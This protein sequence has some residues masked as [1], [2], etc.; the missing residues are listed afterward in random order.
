MAYSIGNNLPTKRQFKQNYEAT[1]HDVFPRMV[2]PALNMLLEAITTGIYKVYNSGVVPFQTALHHQAMRETIFTAAGSLLN[3]EEY[4]RSIK[5]P[6]PGA[7]HTVTG[8]NANSLCNELTRCFTM[9]EG[10]RES[11][12]QIQ[13]W[14][15]S[16]GVD[17]FADKYYS[18]M[19][20]KDK[21]LKWFASFFGVTQ[22]LYDSHARTKLIR[23]SV[24]LVFTTTSQT[25]TSASSSLNS[26]VPLPIAF[27]GENPTQ[28]PDLAG[29]DVG[30]ANL[31]VLSKYILPDL[32]SD[33]IYGDKGYSVYGCMGDLETALHQT[34][35]A[36]DYVGRNT[37]GMFPIME[38]V[39]YAR[40]SVKE[41]YHDHL[42]PRFDLVNVGTSRFVD[43]VS[44][45]IL[46]AAAIYGHVPERNPAHK[47]AEYCGLLFVP[48]TWKLNVVDHPIDD[49]GD[50][51]GLGNIIDFGS[52]SPGVSVK[53]MTS[54]IASMF[55]MKNDGPMKILPKNYN[56]KQVFVPDAIKRNVRI[57][58]AVRV[59]MSQTHTNQTCGA[60][61]LQEVGHQLRDSSTPT[62]VH[63]QA[64]MKIGTDIQ[65]NAKPLLVLFKTDHPRAAQPIVVC[66]T[67]MVNLST[68]GC[69][70]VVDCCPG[71]Q[72]TAT[73]TFD[74][75][76][77]GTFANGDTVLYRSGLHGATV[78]ATVSNANGSTLTLTSTGGELIDCCPST[79]QYGKLGVVVK[80]TGATA[81]VSKIRKSVFT[82]GVLTF[83]LVDPVLSPIAALTPGQIV[84]ADGQV[85]NVIIQT[86][87]NGI[88]IAVTAAV[89]ETCNLSN[90][91]ASSLDGA[92]FTY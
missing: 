49:F 47:E 7:V 55:S 18:D 45:D 32:M 9:T 29:I 77:T 84:L 51:F 67:N 74:K 38:A 90:L 27:N 81:R 10:I 36:M 66:S 76:V 75:P 88:N 15:W 68:R 40:K 52:N 2:E 64:N 62:G 82:A 5:Q 26:T 60:T 79:D 39:E 48:N 54:Q 14:C 92:T 43:A 91:T 35:Y 6:T 58:E 4:G 19:Y 80:I 73:I 89:G 23:D 37:H 50:L 63:V 41:F 16:T 56:G 1:F 3:Y 71:G 44:A 11:N 69:L 13:E 85:V 12:Q 34:A 24:K 86:D 28:F 42:F 57:P 65:G 22:T 46:T 20:Y 72:P 25:F 30:G 53:K 78:F 61:G 8:C 33:I 70:T 17:C 59:V 21:I 31:E 87:M 83:E